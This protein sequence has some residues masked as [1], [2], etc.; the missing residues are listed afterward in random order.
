MTKKIRPIQSIQRAFDII[1]CFDGTNALLSLNEISNKLDL[2]I[3]TTRGIVNTLVYNGY[4]NHFEEVN[5]Y[6]LGLI[7]IPKSE[8]VEDNY[9]ANVKREISPIL[10]TIAKDFEVSSRL[11]IATN[12]NIYTVD[13][14]NPENSRYIVLPKKDTPFPFHATSSGKIFLCFSEKEKKEEIINSIDFKKYTDKTITDEQSLINEMNFIM[15]NGYSKEYEESGYGISSVAVPFFNMK[16]ELQGTI[17][18]TST[19]DII[20]KY[21]SDIVNFIK[22]SISNLDNPFIN[23]YKK[24]C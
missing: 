10:K 12:Y 15:E 2:N 18:V 23:M 24:S 19:T 4:L 5:K 14:A 1:N 21:E 17:S 8:L 16:N 22:K 9:I 20:K 11:Q 6:G 7:F 3:N 13:T